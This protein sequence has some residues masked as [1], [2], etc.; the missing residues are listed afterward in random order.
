MELLIHIDQLTPV[1]TGAWIARNVLGLVPY[2]K[3]TSSIDS[4]VA[5][6]KVHHYQMIAG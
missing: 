2:Q 6:F 5:V 4:G 1:F 3:A